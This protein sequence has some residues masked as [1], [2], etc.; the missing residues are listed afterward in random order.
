MTLTHNAHTDWADS[1]GY[2][3]R[4]EGTPHNGLT[5]FGREVVRE[6]NRLGMIVDVSHISDKTFWDVI[7]TTQAPVFASHSSCRALA[8][9]PRNMTDEMIAAMAKKGGVIHINFGC[10]FL[11]INRPTPRPP[12]APFPAPRLPTWWRTSTTW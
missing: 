5:D 6:M 7:E 2:L 4:A 1:S 10:E 9:I 3:G 11:R 12:T 8:G